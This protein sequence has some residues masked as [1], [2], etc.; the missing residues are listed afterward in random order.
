MFRHR[1][2]ISSL[3]V[4]LAGSAAL[5]QGLRGRAAGRQGAPSGQNFIE[6][7]QQRLNLTPA[8]VDGIRS[9]QENRQKEVQSL[10]QEMRQQ[11]QSLR[12]LLQQSNPNANDVG[13]ATL[14]MKDT[15]MK[16][17]EI[18]QRFLSGVKGLLTPEQLL[19]LP[20]RLR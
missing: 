16:V 6:R 15:R 11:R 14:A 17:R 8:Q 13:Q 10:R 2:L 12:Q 18:N 1:I 9:L 19:Q 4:A 7:L 3:V 20:K 5:A